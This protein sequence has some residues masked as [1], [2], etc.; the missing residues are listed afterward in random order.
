M[1]GPAYRLLS[2]A[3]SIA[4]SAR[5]LGFYAGP[6]ALPAPER[7]VDYLAIYYQRIRDAELRAAT[8]TLFADG[9]YARA[10]EE[11]YKCLNNYIKRRSRLS[12]DGAALMRSVFSPKKPQLKLNKLNSHS[13]HDEQT[14]Y[15]DIYAG[16]MTGIRNPRAHEHRM[17]DAPDEA[18]DLLAWADHLMRKAKQATRPRVSK[19][20]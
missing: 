14:G 7:E 10:V 8:E 6:L 15:M 13:Q 3:H 12:Q 4:K 20:V 5:S 9:H 16:C 17:R 18:L 19:S 1:K 2:V 11:A